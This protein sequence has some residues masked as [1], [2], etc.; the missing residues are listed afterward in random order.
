M[1]I[2]Q[3]SMFRVFVQGIYRKPDLSNPQI[4]A[5]LTALAAPRPPPPAAVA[6]PAAAAASAPTETKE[7]EQEKG[8]LRKELP[9]HEPPK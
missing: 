3:I 6:A 8:K 4:P 9:P 2:P 1:T 7:S 5:T